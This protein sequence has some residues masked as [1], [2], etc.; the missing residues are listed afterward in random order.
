MEAIE[1]YLSE[2]DLNPVRYT[3]NAKGQE[4]LEKIRRARQALEQ[5][6]NE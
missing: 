5:L 2:R 6:N 4:I 3:W 1:A